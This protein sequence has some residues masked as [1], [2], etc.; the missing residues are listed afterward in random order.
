MNI[1]Q[2]WLLTNLTEDE[3]L[4][5]YNIVSLNSQYKNFD[6]DTMVAVKPQIFSQKFMQIQP[7]VNEQGTAVLETLK[8]KILEFENFKL[9]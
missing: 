2:R 1:D 8:N 6:L 4:M 5:F 9:Q 7:L 3:L